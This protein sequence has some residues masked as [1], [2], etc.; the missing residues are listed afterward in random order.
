MPNMCQFVSHQSPGLQFGLHL[1]NVEI[2]A[3]RAGQVSDQR[4]SGPRRL[5][6]RVRHPDQTASVTKS[7]GMSTCWM[8]TC[9][10]SC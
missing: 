6:P 2:K 7:S 4:E 10:L 3:D 1:R 5:V 8:A 9:G